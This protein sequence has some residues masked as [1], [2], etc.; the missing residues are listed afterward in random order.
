MGR[1]AQEELRGRGRPGTW[2][3]RDLEFD[4]SFEQRDDF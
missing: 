2:P 4:L 3:G 1:V